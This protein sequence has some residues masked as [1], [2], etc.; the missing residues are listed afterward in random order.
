M[1]WLSGGQGSWPPLGPVSQPP[2]QGQETVGLG[3]RGLGPAAT[4]ALLEHKMAPGACAERGARPGRP[5]R[6][7]WGLRPRGRSTRGGWLD[8]SLCSGGGLWDAQ[9]CCQ[10]GGRCLLQEASRR[11]GQHWSLLQRCHGYVG[12]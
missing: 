8:Q 7:M 5:Q 3:R 9:S 1:P 2:C 6:S 4:V 10:E 11:L 12:A